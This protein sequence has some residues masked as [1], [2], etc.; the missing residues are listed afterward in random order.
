MFINSWSH[1]LQFFILDFEDTKVTFH[2]S[3]VLNWLANRFKIQISKSPSF[4]HIHKWSYVLLTTTKSAKIQKSQFPISKGIHGA[5][6][7]LNNKL[8]FSK[9]HNTF[10]M[11]F[12]IDIHQNHILKW[13]LR[14][15]KS[16]FKFLNCVTLQSHIWL[17]G[18]FG[19]LILHEI[20]ISHVSAGH[21]TCSNPKYESQH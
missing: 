2:S 19:S 4:Y 10:V 8:R 7:Q 18:W 14:I 21:E 11:S 20:Q 15:Q 6:S 12:C 1:V 13:P 5:I 9:S 17:L 16:H 3:Q